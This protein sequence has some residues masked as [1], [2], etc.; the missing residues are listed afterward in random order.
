MLDVRQ[1]HLL[2][3]LDGKDAMCAAVLAPIAEDA[4]ED[5]AAKA[6]TMAVT[7]YG[8][9]AVHDAKDVAHDAAHDASDLA[10]D[11]THDVKDLAHKLHLGGQGSH[12]GPMWR[13]QGGEGGRPPPHPTVS[14][15]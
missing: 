7:K 1:V 4:A 10:H 13:Y 2:Q 6:A 3:D 9:E 5:A 8:P 12:A 15:E 11:A 14:M